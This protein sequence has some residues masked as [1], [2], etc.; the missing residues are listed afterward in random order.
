MTKEKPGWAEPD[1]DTSHAIRAKL[2]N[3]RTEALLEKRL[4]E[5]DPPLSDEETSIIPKLVEMAI[6]KLP[7]EKPRDFSHVHRDSLIGILD[8]LREAGYDHKDLD[9]NNMSKSKLVEYLT[10]VVRPEIGIAGLTYHPRLTRDILKNKYS[11]K[12]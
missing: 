10:V 11:P 3:Q 9:Y 12:G 8:R 5:M 4:S 1:K 6:P 2:E 7:G